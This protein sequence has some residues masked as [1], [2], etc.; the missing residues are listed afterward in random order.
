LLGA[1]G[2]LAA[3]AFAATAGEPVPAAALVAVCETCHRA[4][5][6]DIPL[7]HGRPADE[8]ARSLRAFPAQADATVM[9]RIA[10]GLSAAEIDAVARALSQA[11][12]PSE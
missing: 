6:A 10:A 11:P 5:G 9:H 8:L 3:P 7:I 2:P 4:D 1:L 12:A